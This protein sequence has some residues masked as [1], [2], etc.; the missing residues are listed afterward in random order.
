MGRSPL[1]RKQ[2]AACFLLLVGVDGM[3]LAAPAASPDIERDLSRKEKLAVLVARVGAYVE[4]FHAEMASVVLE[5]RYVQI[6][7]QPCCREPRSPGEDEALAWDPDPAA[8]RRRGLLA[9]RRVAADLLCVRLIDG[10]R[11]VYRDVFEVDGL[12][13]EGRDERARKLFFSGTEES[14]L[15]LSRIAAENARFNLGQLR[16]TTNLPTMPF[17]YLSP[18]LHG[19]LF[20]ANEGDETVDGQA[21]AGFSFREDASPTV[22]SSADG[23]DMPARGQLWV[24]PDSGSIRRIELR[25]G[26]RKTPR[27]VMR[28][29]FREDPRVSVLVPDRMWEWYERVEARDPSTGERVNAW[30]ADLEG[31]AT[32][33]NLRLFTVSTTEE[34]VAPVP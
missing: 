10:R 17:H 34:V 20:F 9:R 32:Y 12:P 25:L 23:S 30:P 21:V 15:E 29:W 28:V 26:D 33:S 5:E 31:F 1:S 18:E 8:K 16:R 4:R 6:L 27:R 3:L 11:F 7:K 2:R 22:A 24:E 14:R 19:R 13:F